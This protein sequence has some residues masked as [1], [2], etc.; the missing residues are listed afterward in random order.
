MVHYQGMRIF[1]NCLKLGMELIPVYSVNKIDKMMNAFMDFP[2]QSRGLHL[3]FL[4]NISRSDEEEVLQ[5]A[6]LKKIS[7][8]LNSVKQ[9]STKTSVIAVIAD[10]MSKL[11]RINVAENKL[12]T[13]K[14]VFKLVSELCHRQHWVRSDDVID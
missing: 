6:I 10:M 13:P 9:F 4:C 3:K 1:R 7:D 2:K 12:A 5:A 8:L 14:N 11:V